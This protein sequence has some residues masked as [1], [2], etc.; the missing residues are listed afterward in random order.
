MKGNIVSLVL[1]IRKL[2]LKDYKGCAPIMSRLQKWT[3][4]SGFLTFNSVKTLATEFVE[5]HTC[6]WVLTPWEAALRFLEL[7]LPCS[8]YLGWVDPPR[9][10][11]LLWFTVLE[12]LS[13]TYLPFLPSSGMDP[14]RTQRRHPVLLGKRISGWIIPSCYYFL[15]SVL[16]ELHILPTQSPW[17]TP[18]TQHTSCLDLPMTHNFPGTGKERILK[19]K[20][21]FF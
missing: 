17:S 12:I 19:A 13:Q 7:E 11:P 16:T 1:Q 8:I 10:Q 6:G 3:S 2:R 5:S 15:L 14:S 20:L 9:R 4:D 18:Q 21:I